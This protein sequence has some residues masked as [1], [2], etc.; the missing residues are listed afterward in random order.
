MRHRLWSILAASASLLVLSACGS[1]AQSQ[2][3]TAYGPTQKLGDGTVRTYVTT[4]VAGI[5]SDVGIQLTESALNGLPPNDQE[6]ILDF[7]QQVRATDFNHVMLNWNSHGHPPAGVFD[8][9]HFDMHFYMDDNASVMAIDPHNPQFAAQASHLP[10]QKYVPS[11]YAPE[12]GGPP[13]QVAVPMMG[14]HWEDHPN[15]FV[16]NHYNF[17]QVL[18]N[19]SWD[20]RYTF[21]EPMITRAWLLS[22]PP[23]VQGEV[24]QPAAFQRTGYFP[25]TY[26]IQYDDAS[27]TYSISLG[28]MK[29]H[30]AG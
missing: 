16:P 9:P 20:G 22:K 28:G 4:D 5:P 8:V 10:D 1:G 25:T 26:R 30:Q 19:G 6:F 14:L 15:T 23:T 27:K 3:G 7:P 21:V 29:M 11:G 12:S 13:A 18:L 2:A 24:N 17:T